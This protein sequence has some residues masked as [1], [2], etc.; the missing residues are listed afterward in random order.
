MMIAAST[1]LGRWCSKGV[2]NSSASSTKSAEN[3]EDRPV[4]ACTDRLS[5]EREN[6]PLT[7]MVWLNAPAILASPWPISS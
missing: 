7:G 3:I 6:E 5:A 4:W 2:K 1:G